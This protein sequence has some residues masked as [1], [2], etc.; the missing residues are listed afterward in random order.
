MGE[1]EVE[2]S[3]LVELAAEVVAA[4][5]SNNPLPKG[6]QPASSED[7]VFLTQ[8]PIG[9]S[10]FLMKPGST[11]NVWV[12]CYTSTALTGTGIVT[13]VIKAQTPFIVVEKLG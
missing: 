13:G 11:Y 4:F 8:T 10:Y 5:I 3:N 1:S 7:S 2:T 6:G 12:W 9:Q